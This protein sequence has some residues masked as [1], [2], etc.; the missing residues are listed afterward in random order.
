MVV[1]RSEEDQDLD[2]RKERRFNSFGSVRCP[3][4]YRIFLLI[5]NKANH[6]PL[7]PAHGPC[8]LSPASMENHDHK[9]QKGQQVD[10]TWVNE[11]K[12]YKH[13]ITR[14]LANNQDSQNRWLDRMNSEA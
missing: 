12:I 11:K 7:Q 3:H 5:V 4:S 2:Q 1:T 14:E 10:T 6:N 8:L 9:I 13:C